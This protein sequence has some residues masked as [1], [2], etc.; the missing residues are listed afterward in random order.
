LRRSSTEHADSFCSGSSQNDLGGTATEY[1]VLE[2]V[3]VASPQHLSIVPANRVSKR[4]LQEGQLSCTVRAVAQH[5][6][7]IA[8]LTSAGVRVVV[9]KPVAGLPDLAFTR[10]TSL[11]TPWG[12]I[13]LRPGA[14]HRKSEVDVVLHAAR[15]ASLPILGRVEVGCVEGGDVCLLSP[16]YVAIGVSGQRTDN[17][18]AYALGSFFQREGWTPIYTAIDP[19]LLHLDTHFSMVGPELALGCVEKLEPA[20]LDQ[21]ASFGIKVVPVTI[22]EVSSLACNIL[23]LGDQRV[24]ST[25]SSPRLDRALQKLGFDVRTVALDEFTQCGG[26]VHCL[27][28]PLRRSILKS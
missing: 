14:S 18:G 19:D 20:F 26:G 28:M 13:G 22:D 25:G 17:V 27:T 1:D 11:M 8:E 23:S 21:V 10:D 4:S 7:L 9:V 5:R 3:L 16:G 12:L 6:A 2:E 15:E 24:V